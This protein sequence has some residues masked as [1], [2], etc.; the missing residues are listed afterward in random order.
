MLHAPKCTSL[1]AM[2]SQAGGKESSSLLPSSTSLC[3]LTPHLVKSLLC[4][5]LPLTGAAL[6]VP[7]VHAMHLH[8]VNWG[9]CN[10]GHYA[11]M[12]PSGDMPPLDSMCTLLQLLFLL[13]NR[14][15]CLHAE[16][17][18]IWRAVARNRRDLSGRAQPVSMSVIRSVLDNAP[19]K[20]K[21]AWTGCQGRIQG[22][23]SDIGRRHP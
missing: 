12:F 21:A 6:S 7:A 1:H 20:M 10:A 15:G 2:M 17:Q 5:Q 11:Q 14:L 22:L 16:I 19:R 13:L 3:Y 8:L 18:D 23:K 9:T 4:W